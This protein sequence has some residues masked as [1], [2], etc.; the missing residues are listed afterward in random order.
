MV[1]PECKGRHF[2]I[3]TSAYDKF[4]GRID[5]FH[6]FGCLFRQSSILIHGLVTDLPWTVHFI[7]EAPG[8]ESIW[9]LLSVFNTKIAVFGS[10]RMV[11]VFQKIACICDSSCS[12]IDCHHNL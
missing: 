9:I 5:Q 1:F 7:S 3:G 4:D 12:Q 2:L 10:A 8:F 11:T 6:C